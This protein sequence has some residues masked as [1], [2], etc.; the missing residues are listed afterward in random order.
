[1]N[2]FSRGKEVALLHAPS[3]PQR[4]QGAGKRCKHIASDTLNITVFSMLYKPFFLKCAFYS[5]NC[6]QFEALLYFRWSRTNRR[7]ACKT[8]Q[9][10]HPHRQYLSERVRVKNSL[11][12]QRV[13]KG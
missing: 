1:M 12:T 10:P 9:N 13:G 7:N 4:D 5:V 2:D 3:L 8:Q 11:K 6:A